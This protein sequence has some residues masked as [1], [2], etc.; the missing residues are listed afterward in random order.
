MRLSRILTVAA[1]ALGVFVASSSLGFAQDLGVGDLVYDIEVE[2]NQRIEA[3]T[4]RSYMTIRVGDPFDPGLIDRSLKSLFSTGLFADVAFRREGSILIARVVENPIINRVAF[5]GN[6]KFEDEQLESEV[7]LR[8]RIVYTRTRVQNDVQRIIE[9]YRRSGRFAA[10]VEPKVIR[11]SD[12]RVDLVFEVD[13]GPITEVRKISFVGNSK[14]SD[15][16]L[17][18]VI[19]TQQTAWWRIFSSADIYDP[20]AVTFDRELLRRY[21]L[22]NGYADFRVISAVAELTRNREAFFITFTVEEGRR[23]RFGRVSVESLLRDLPSDHLLPILT[24]VPEEWYDADE[25]ETTILALT[26]EVGNL[27]YAFIDIQPDVIPDRK[28]GTIDVNYIVNEGPRV[29]VERIDIAGNSRTLD[30][31]VRREFRFVE[32]DAF[33]TAK[34]RRSKARIENLGFFSSVE[35]EALP[36]TAPDQTIIRVDVTE[37]ATGTI[38]LGGGFSTFD[39]PLADFGIQEANLLGRGQTLRLSGQVSSRRQLVDLSFVEPYLFDRDLSGGADVFRKSTDNRRE[40]SFSQEEFGFRVNIGYSVTEEIRHTVRYLLKQDKIEDVKDDASRFI[41]EQEGSSVVSVV[42][43]TLAYDLRDSRVFPREGYFVSF[44]QD[45][46]G[47]GGSEKFL[48]H[49]VNYEIYY[50]VSEQWIASFTFE[51][52]FIFG[53]AGDD[54][55]ISQRYFLGGHKL[56]GFRSAGVGPRD[57]TTGDALG[58]NLLYT[59]SIQ[60]GFPITDS[61]DFPVRGSI[62]TDIGSLSRVDDDDPNIFDDGSPRVGIGFGLSYVSPFGPVGFDLTHAV[63]KEDADETEI[64]RINF[65]TTF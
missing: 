53:F 45:L 56:R 54:V 44:A 42:G 35:V 46:A 7:Q 23:Y 41:E 25:V 19:Q 31:V 37:Q 11:L 38:N 4:V 12:N 28:R 40:S 51:E 16:E 14:F 15:D 18:G 32:G 24:T 2:G 30:E 61:S 47:L 27:G 58:G 34:F 17:R 63:I 49:Q 9:I 6:D 62:F 52:S 55:R 26:D 3:E 59:S 21:Y 43:H 36:G 57:L 64:F 39:G 8:P 1:L 33:N 10:T 65:G 5:E 48:S 29:Y 50:P 60:L 22:S 20:D 13:E